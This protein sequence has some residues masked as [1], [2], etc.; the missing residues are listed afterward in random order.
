MTYDHG[1]LRTYEIVW[2]SGH[3]ETVQGH[4]VSFSGG[5]YALFD[6]GPKAPVRFHIHGQFD[7]HWRL[8]LAELED[9]V[10]IIRDVT[11]PEQ[12][13]SSGEGDGHD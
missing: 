1:P 6:N 7:G 3:V 8:V 4:Q 9:D 11:E 13:K 12:I 5:Q 10:A 2:R